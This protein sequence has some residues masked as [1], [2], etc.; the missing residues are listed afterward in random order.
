[1]CI[2]DSITGWWQVRGRSATSFEEMVR[3][4]VDYITRQS[5]WLDIKIIFMT[6]TAVINGKGAR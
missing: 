1:M 4:D 6:L 2:R 5:L 3:M